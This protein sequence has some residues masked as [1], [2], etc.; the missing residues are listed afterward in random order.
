LEKD[1]PAHQ[2]PKQAVAGREQRFEQKRMAQSQEV[3][4]VGRVGQQ[5][6]PEDGLPRQHLR[7][8]PEGEGPERRDALS[9]RRRRRSAELGEQ[10]SGR[11]QQ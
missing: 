3:A 8:R 7:K 11:Q 1:P 9:Q 4:P 6:D 2:S 10:S 5:V